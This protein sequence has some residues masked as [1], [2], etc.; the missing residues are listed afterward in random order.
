MALSWTAWQAKR[1][2]PSASCHFLLLRR[3]S[4]APG[5]MPVSAVPIRNLHNAAWWLWPSK[6][7]NTTCHVSM[8]PSMPWA[9]LGLGT[10]SSALT[11]DVS[12]NH[13]NPA[14]QIREV[15][16]HIF[17]ARPSTTASRH[18]RQSK[19]ETVRSSSSGPFVTLY[20][21][22]CLSFYIIIG[23]SAE[24]KWLTTFILQSIPV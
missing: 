23:F 1:C 2:G 22:S 4:V 21:V 14:L 12:V 7:P 10:L 6:R 3:R 20:G 16:R 9:A 8:L 18:Y 5:G 19:Q 17:T 15:T 24:L 11:L 13:T